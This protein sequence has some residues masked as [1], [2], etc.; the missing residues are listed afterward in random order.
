[1]MTPLQWFLMTSGKDRGA[2]T[3]GSQPSQT[4][5]STN[6]KSLA[7]AL[8]VLGLGA[9]A[10]GAGIG[11]SMDM[12]RMRGMGTP[13]NVDQLSS[14][15]HFGN[16]FSGGLVGQNFPGQ[17]RENFGGMGVNPADNFSG[18]TR[19]D[20]APGVSNDRDN[21]GRGTRTGPNRGKSA[22]F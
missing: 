7:N 18:L 4:G 3:Q 16:A 6:A 1:M 9:R 21:I 17:V 22:H 8:S 2:Q 19:G 10:I 12:N 5:G 20:T 14:M 15:S 11:T 13:Q